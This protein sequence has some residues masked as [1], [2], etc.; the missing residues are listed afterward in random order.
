MIFMIFAYVLLPL[1]NILFLA[2]LEV[3]YSSLP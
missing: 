1:A 2:L 3:K